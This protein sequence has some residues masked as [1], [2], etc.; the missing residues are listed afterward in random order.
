MKF[1]KFNFVV[2][3]V[4]TPFYLQAV[5]YIYIQ[6]IGVRIGC[7][8]LGNLNYLIIAKK[9]CFLFFLVVCYVHLTFTIA[10]STAQ[11]GFS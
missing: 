10:A 1:L 4:E 7:Y 8:G 9:V 11:S 6:Q 5:L 2:V 3:V